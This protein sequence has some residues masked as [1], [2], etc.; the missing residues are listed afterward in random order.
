MRNLLLHP[1]RRLVKGPALLAAFAAL[2]HS[3]PSFAGVNRWTSLGPYREGGIFTALAVDPKAP[4]IVYAGT[5]GNGIFRSTD[6]GTTWS[7]V[8]ESL[9]D[10]SIFDIVVDPASP[11]EY[12]VT[13]GGLFKSMNGGLNWSALRNGLPPG[14]SIGDLAI[15]PVSSSTLYATVGGTG[16]FKS[17]DGGTSWVALLQGLE[18][19]RV[20]GIAVDARTP[21]NLYAGS[22]NGLFK[23]TDG[24]TTWRR[25]PA[26]PSGIIVLV[27]VE[28]VSSAVYAGTFD[29][30]FRSGDGGATWIRLGGGLPASHVRR[31]VIAPGSGSPIYA[32]TYRDGIFRSTDGGASW[33][34]ANGG[35]PDLLATN[36]LAVDPTSPSTLYAGLTNLSN[37]GVFKSTDRGASWARAPGSFQQFFIVRVRTH[38][39]APGIVWAG[40][41][42]AGVLRSTDGGSTWSAQNEG[43][44][45]PRI[46][47]LEVA[48]SSSLVLYA[49]TDAGVFR[50]LNGGANWEPANEGLPEPVEGLPEPVTALAVD[51]ASS[52][53]LY[54]GSID[55]VSPYAI[56]KSVNAGSTWTSVKA[57]LS[58]YVGALAAVPGT[59]TTVYAGLSDGGGL[60]K[61]VDGGATWSPLA[62]EG[63]AGTSITSLALDPGTPATIY[64]VSAYT[65]GR[66]GS[67]PLPGSVF[68]SVDGG[69]RWMRILETLDPI[70]IAVNPF[71]PNEVYLSKVGGVLRSRDGGANWRPAGAGL[72]GIPSS[73]AFAPGA[74]STVYAG[75]HLGLFGANFT[76]TAEGNCGADSVTLCLQ[77]SRFSVQIAWRTPTGPTAAGQSLPLT[78]DT[79]A[80]WFFQSPNLELMV[81][82]LDGRAINGRF[83]VFCG[84]LT[85]V[86]FT[87]TVTDTQTG[88]VRTYSNPPGQLASF[89]DTGAF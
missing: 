61:S 34:A 22:T 69:L 65:G 62:V 87:L 31:L 47:E 21:T 12:A 38:A 18:E 14:Q 16:V 10:W 53:T 70:R 1:V 46:R 8:N 2:V 74:P 20:F 49:G 17:L 78:S 72:F 44:T 55:G 86:E 45:N 85:N 23:T 75:T 11:A 28:P 39:N 26:S 43:L 58:T 66:P 40:T 41:L 64:A 27:E 35:L 71:S 73:Y 82:V 52:S 84:S 48:P 36:A 60:L 9:A 19:V 88:A 59:P 29:G 76:A 6:A 63:L 79:G 50:S 13:G 83:W 37:G 7:P 56:Y 67:L 51:P 3:S 32:M 15:G 54:A 4:S 89:A 30:L 5:S 42:D 68:K 77:D 25:L 57:G 81:K 24:G 33:T 80:F